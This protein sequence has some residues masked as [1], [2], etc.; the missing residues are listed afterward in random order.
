MGDRATECLDVGTNMNRIRLENTVFEGLNNAYVFGADTDG[1]TTL[2]DTGI[3]MAETHDQ[4]VDGLAQLDLGFA[5]IDEILLTH[6]HGDHAGL[7]GA[8]QHEGGATVRAHAADAPL[9]ENDPDAWAAMTDRQRTLIERWGM[10]DGPREELEAFLAD[11]DGYAET[12]PTVDSFEDGARFRTSEG[13]LEA[14]HLPGHAAGLS[15]F[16]FDGEDGLELL[17]GDALLP[18]YTPNVGG[19]DVR[20]DRPL[21]RYLRT[22]EH[23]ADGGFVRAWPGHRD[24]IEDPAARAKEIAVHHRERTGNVVDVLAEHGPA[25]AWTVSARLFGDLSGIH[26]LHGPG[27]AYAHL[28]HLTTHGVTERAKE[29]YRL[30]ASDP[31]LDSLFPALAMAE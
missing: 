29:G 24:P 3:A 5:D 31:D 9:I 4:L 1:P 27:E 13:D 19:A 2:V 8:I 12:A 18:H 22:L 17:S 6:W 30:V 11:E 7:A 16:V 10:P 14:R 21:E 15:G 20:V 25:D 28:D 26:I 23:I